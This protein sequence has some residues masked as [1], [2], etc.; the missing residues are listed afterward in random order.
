MKKT[1]FATFLILGLVFFSCDYVKDPYPE[2][3]ANIG[4]TTTCPLPSFPV[5]SSHVKKI[6]IEDFTGHTCGNCPKAA[7]ELHDIDSIYPG[8]IIGLGLHVGGY[9]APTPGYNG[10]VSTSY[11]AD[12]RT[13]VGELYDAT[14]GASEFGLPQGMFNRKEYDAVNKTHLQFYPNWKT[15]VAGIIAEP[16]VVDLQISS[17]FNSSTRKVC[18]AVRDSF[19]TTMSGTFNLVVLLTQDSIIDWQ[20]Y[21]GVNK[22]EYIHRHVLRDAITPLGA[23]GELIEA[24]NIAV[25][26]KHVTRFAYTIPSSYKGSPCDVTKCHIVAYLYNTATYEII[27]SEE[28]K[29]IP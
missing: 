9:A 17:D 25:G 27:Q 1:L 13:T 4:D 14:F 11:L 7:K 24:G 8:K 21:I 16:S 28:I 5:V 23:F 3:N 6:F 12:Y 18:T 15:Y 29:V 19:L 22:A 26:A 2:T 20:D 10:S